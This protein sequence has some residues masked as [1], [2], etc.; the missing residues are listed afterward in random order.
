MWISA[1]TPGKIDRSAKLK[2]AFK[3]YINIHLIDTREIIHVIS[4]NYE[5][6]AMETNVTSAEETFTFTETNKIWE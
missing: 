5:E 2:M 4:T 3:I 6:K 1:V